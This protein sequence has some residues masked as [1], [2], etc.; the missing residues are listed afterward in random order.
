M[1]FH[2]ARR[3]PDGYGVPTPPRYGAADVSNVVTLS[4][5]LSNVETAILRIEAKLDKL[6]AMMLPVAATFA[7]KGLRVAVGAASTSHSMRVRK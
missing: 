7:D 2:P 5:R 6:C 1:T 4:S 3:E